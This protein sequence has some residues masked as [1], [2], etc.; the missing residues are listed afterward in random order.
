[1]RVLLALGAIG[2][3]EHHLSRALCERL[4][5]MLTRLCRSRS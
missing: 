5:A 2:P 1:L 3:E 4:Y